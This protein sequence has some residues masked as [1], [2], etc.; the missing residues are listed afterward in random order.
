MPLWV[1]AKVPNFPF[2]FLQVNSNILYIIFQ[3]LNIQNSSIANN[4]FIWRIERQQAS[5]IKLIR[6]DSTHFENI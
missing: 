2:Q 1:P 4:Q 3:K 5:I 6:S